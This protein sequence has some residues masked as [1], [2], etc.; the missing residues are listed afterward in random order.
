MCKEERPLS[1]VKF[2]GDALS[3]N[4]IA[5]TPN[6]EAN[7]TDNGRTPEEISVFDNIYLPILTRS[8]I[9]ITDQDREEM[10][11][12]GLSPIPE[13]HVTWARA[14]QAWR[15]FEQS[16]EMQPAQSPVR[17]LLD[18]S[19]RFEEP[20]EYISDPG[21][22]T[23]DL[24]NRSFDLPTLESFLPI[25]P[26][27]TWSVETEDAH[28]ASSNLTRLSARLPGT[29]GRRSTTPNQLQE[30]MNTVQTVSSRDAM[31]GNEGYQSL[32]SS[33]SESETKEGESEEG[34]VE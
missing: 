20:E 17:W 13:E 29:E 14:D 6:P 26:P 12:R 33:D 31:F 19:M 8:G 23:D 15:S 25:P 2:L 22:P 10:R 3:L 1:T 30:L 18:E 32:R 7:Q 21:L 9:P 11:L 4:H 24:G 5:S 16:R 34:E 28:T 27:E